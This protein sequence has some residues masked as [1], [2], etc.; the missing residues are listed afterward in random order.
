MPATVISNYNCKSVDN[1][2]KHPNK[3]LKMLLARAEEAGGQPWF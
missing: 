2:A 1:D 3:V